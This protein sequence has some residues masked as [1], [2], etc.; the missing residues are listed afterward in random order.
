MSGNIAGESTGIIISDNRDGYE[1]LI[2]ELQSLMAIVNVSAD[3]S[4]AFAV[5]NARKPQVVFVDLTLDYPSVRQ[6]MEQVITR[7]TGVSVIA[8]GGHQDSERILELFRLGITDYLVLPNEIHRVLPRVEKILQKPN[9]DIKAGRIFSL[10]SPKGGQGITSLA[11][12]LA[13]Q[14]HALTGEKVLLLDLNLFMGNIGIYLNISAG[15]TIFDLLKDRKRMDANLLFSSLSFHANRFYVLTTPAEVSDAERISGDDL[16]S[17]LRLLKKY[18]DYIVIDLPHDFT[19]KNLTAFEASDE[20]ILVVQ[21]SVPEIKSMQT[22]LTLFHEVRRDDEALKM[23]V[24]RYQKKNDLNTEDIAAVLKKPVMATVANDYR[25][26]ANVINRGKTLAE[27]ERKS[28]IAGD[29]R[30]I[31]VR[32]LDPDAV[33][34]K[35]PVWKRWIERVLR[36]IR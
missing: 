20:L 5:I 19:E 26:L 35:P 21:Q 31:A 8:F 11:I 2:R 3:L 25:T 10:F 16:T 1:T 12:N 27:A 17:I 4:S 6:L 33:S 30:A 32:L 34:E 22:A 9:S 15:Y 7:M 24:N 18:F 14:I 13:D 23:I 29:I 36:K 28:N